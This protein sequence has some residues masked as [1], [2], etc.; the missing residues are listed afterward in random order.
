MSY[1][2]YDELRRGLVL[3]LP[4]S[5]GVGTKVFDTSQYRNNGTFGAGAAAP[6]WVGGREGRRALSFDA[7]DDC[8]SVLDSPSLRITG[9]F[10]HLSW[11]KQGGAHEDGY[12]G[13]WFDRNVNRL[14]VL[15]GGYVLVQYTIG[16]EPVSFQTAI[17]KAPIDTWTLV[18]LTYDGAE[19]A[20]WIDGVKNTANPAEGAVSG[21]TVTRYIGWAHTITYHFDGL[22]DG[23]RIYNRALDPY[24]IRALYEAVRKI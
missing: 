22:I 24:E 3:H 19:L 9:N 1:R 23:V 12:G 21:S 13:I 7:L 17:N 11:I 20:I 16:G 14:L 8:V 6:T 15:D 4:L 10:T 2:G 18:G 5:E